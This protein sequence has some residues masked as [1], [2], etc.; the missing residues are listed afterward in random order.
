MENTPSQK[1]YVD[2]GLLYFFFVD[3]FLLRIVV[4]GGGG[5][6]PT[7][8]K[9]STNLNLHFSIGDYK[10]LSIFEKSLRV[11]LKISAL[12]CVGARL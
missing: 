9:N 2:F 8:S 5:M 3:V 10:N 1:K 11:H 4:G 7:V 12:R 6:F